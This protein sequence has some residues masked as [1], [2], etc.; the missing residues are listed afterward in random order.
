MSWP[1]SR[2]ST[3]GASITCHAVCVTVIWIVLLS[4]SWALQAGTQTSDDFTNE[5]SVETWH[6]LQLAFPM[7]ASPLRFARRQSDGTWLWV[8]D[9]FSIA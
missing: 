4:M 5:L 8:I 2:L 3:G 6:S 9:Q 7:A 1:R